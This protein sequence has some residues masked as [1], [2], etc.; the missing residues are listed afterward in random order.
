MEE[1]NVSRFTSVTLVE[2]RG[3]LPVGMVIHGTGGTN[4]LRWM[5]RREVDPRKKSSADYLI[6]RDGKRLRITPFN[7]MTYHSGRATWNGKQ[8]KENSLNRTHFGVELEMLNDGVQNPTSEQYLSLA[9]L[10]VHCFLAWQWDPADTCT[11]AECALPPG[12]KI[13]PNPFSWPRFTSEVNHV[14]QLRGVTDRRVTF[15][16]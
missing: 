10:W 8:D 15:R 2:P 6:R 13:D 9:T 3:M 1:E 12:R 11:H 14:L 4:S 16:A 5:Q 7:Y